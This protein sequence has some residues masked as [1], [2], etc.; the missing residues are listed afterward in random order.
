[1]SSNTHP[2]DEIVADDMSIPAQA[3]PRHCVVMMTG[4]GLKYAQSKGL[5]CKQ[6]SMH[7]QGA[8]V[9]NV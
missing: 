1:M 6:T 3:K 8:Y 9:I 4:P 2:S 7:Q 5:Q